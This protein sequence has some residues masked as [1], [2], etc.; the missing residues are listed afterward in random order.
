MVIWK[1]FH[2]RAVKIS[3]SN[4][5]MCD[6]LSSVSKGGA[7]PRLLVATHSPTPPTGRATESNTSSSHTRDR[8]C[9]RSRCSFVFLL[10]Q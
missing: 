9:S 1:T 2:L 8:R 6:N 10:T 7:G 5:K 4:N 3:V